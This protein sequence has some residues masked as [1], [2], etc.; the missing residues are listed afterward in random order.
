MHT[1][2]ELSGSYWPIA[3]NAIPHSDREYSP[4]DFRDR[5]EALSRAGFTGMGIWHADLEYVQ[6]KYALSEMKQILDDNGIK[7]L[8]L[9]FLTGWF[10]EDDRR[11]ESDRIRA[12]ML[13][14]AE[15]LSPRHLKVGH[16]QKEDV[17]MSHLSESFAQLCEDAANVGTKVGYEMM[18][19]GMTP[20]LE[21]SMELIEGAGADNGGITLD[22]WH[23]VKLGITDD[24]LTTLIPKERLIS[25]ELNDGYLKSPPG[26]G[27]TEETTC[28]RLFC[29]EGQFDLQRFLTNLRKIGYDGPYGIEVLNKEVREWPLDKI[30]THA[31]ATT[32]A[33]LVA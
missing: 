28:H 27:I 24:A 25:V 19:G 33:Q 32:M 9:E 7:N 6:K 12:M 16:F 3:G 14:A 22:S 15:T 31:Y 10:F 1:K 4:F 21:E 13:E 26:M 5:V 18:P 11:K 30:A 2:V 17:S 29:G 20:N 23:V 8:E